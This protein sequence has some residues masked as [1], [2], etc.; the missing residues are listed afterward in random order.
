MSIL[1]LVARDAS[2]REARLWCRASRSVSPMDSITDQYYSTP[3]T[4]QDKTCPP[5]L[6]DSSQ[7]EDASV[8][9]R[10]G[11]L[12]THDKLYFLPQLVPRQLCYCSAGILLSKSIRISRGSAP[13]FGPTTPRSSSKSM[14]RAARV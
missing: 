2:S 13:L 8:C 5:R 7:C 9:L 4:S 12:S 14:I 1:I 11:R 10:T 3:T 6:Q